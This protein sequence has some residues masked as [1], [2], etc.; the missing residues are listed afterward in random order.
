MLFPAWRGQFGNFTGLVGT[1]AFKNITEIFK[2]INIAKLVTG[3][4]AVAQLK[5][6][7]QKQKC[8]YWII[9]SLK[10]INHTRKQ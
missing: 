10:R 6:F 5:L 4:E 1:D 3:N 2:W 9:L 7:S 8:G